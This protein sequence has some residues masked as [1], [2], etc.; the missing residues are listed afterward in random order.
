MIAAMRDDRGDRILHPIAHS[1]RAQIVEYQHF[2]FERDPVR[3]AVRCAGRRVV[4]GTDALQQVLIVKEHG[5]EPACDQPLDHRYGQV[6]FASAGIADEQQTFLPGQ[7]R[8]VIR[9]LSRGGR[10]V[11]ERTVRNGIIR[12]R[13]EILERGIAIKRR[14]VGGAQETLRTSAQRT[15][16]AF[17]A[18][19]A[20]TFH[21]AE[22][23][24]AADRADRFF[25]S[26]RS[27]VHSMAASNSPAT[28]VSPARACNKTTRPARGAGISF[29]IFIASTTTIPC[30]AAT[31][32][33]S[34][35]S[36]RTTLPGIV[37]ISSS[38]PP[39]CAAAPGFISRGSIT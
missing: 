12:S 28:T 24:T 9:V 11:L 17:R 27:P 34:S 19:Q 16:A 31:S 2:A 13:V 1:M 39:A 26:H 8:E 29:C 33:P 21:D 10:S 22:P 6:C 20:V 32:A 25:L 23:A 30:P 3:F 4:A 15:V 35:T 14:D 36:K 18:F 7:N 38:L 5:L 37:A